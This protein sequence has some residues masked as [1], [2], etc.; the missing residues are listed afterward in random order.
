MLQLNTHDSYYGTIT[1]L[2]V[3]PS[4][5]LISAE[6]VE[7]SIEALNAIPNYDNLECRIGVY[8]AAAKSYS[9][10]SSTGK[11]TI[12]CVVPSYAS[13]VTDWD[14]SSDITVTVDVSNNG[15]EF[16]S[17]SVTFV[18]INQLTLVTNIS[19]SRGPITAGS[20][21]SVYLRKTIV[22]SDYNPVCKFGDVSVA[23]TL[24]SA[25]VLACSTK[26]VFAK[27]SPAYVRCFKDYYC[28]VNGSF[29]LQS[30]SYPFSYVF[31]PDP[32][33]TSL[34]P[35]TSGGAQT[36]SVLVRGTGMFSYFQSPAAKFLLWGG[37]S[38]Q[39]DCQSTDYNTSIVCTP[40]YGTLFAT[41]PTLPQ[42]AEV[43]MSV[44]SGLD[45]SADLKNFTFSA[46][47]VPSSLSTPSGPNTGNTNLTIKYT[48]IFKYTDPANYDGYR[49]N[50]TTSANQA[51]FVVPATLNSTVEEL[52]CVTPA[53]DKID[54]T[55]SGL[56]YIA[57]SS[58]GITYSS[59]KLT[60][61]Y[62]A[63]AS[64]TTIDSPYLM[65]D[66]QATRKITGTFPAADSAITPKIRLI[67]AGTTKSQVL[68][69]LSYSTTEVT[70]QTVAGIFAFGD[71][72]QLAISLNGGANFQTSPYVLKAIG[73]AALSSVL[74]TIIHLGT[75]ASVINLLGA[76]FYNLPLYCVQG[77]ASPVLASRL[78]SRLI[79]CSFPG[80]ASETTATI[81]VNIE[82]YPYSANT[83]S[84]QYKAV[85]TVTGISQSAVSAGKPYN[86]TFTLGA[87]GFSPLYVKIS[88]LVFLCVAASSTT[89]TAA[90]PGLS[91]P[92]TASI[93]FS[94]N[95]NYFQQSSLQ[96][97]LQSCVAGQVCPSSF[98]S[99]Q[100]PTTCTAGTICPD[101]GYQRPCPPGYYQS[102]TG[103]S[104]C[105]VCPSGSYCPTQGTVAPLTCPDGYLCSSLGT[106]FKDEM[107]T[108]PE[109]F[110]CPAGT[111]SFDRSKA[112]AGTGYMYYC[113]EGFWCGY[114]VTTG[115]N[116]YGRFSTAQKCND[117][118]VCTAG[119]IDQTGTKAC[120][121][122]YYCNDGIQSV[123]DIGS[124][125]PNAN[126]TAPMKCPPGLFSNTTGQTYCGPCPLGTVC[127]VQGDTYPYKCPPG[128]VC[129]LSG[130]VLFTLLCP[131]GS[132]CVG[133]IVTNKTT[134]TVL[135]AYRPHLCSAGTYCLP[136]TRTNEVIAG[137]AGAAQA[138]MEG[139]YCKEGSD[140]QDYCPEGYYCPLGS[141]PI[142]ADPGYFASGKGNVNEEACAPGTY[143]SGYASASCTVCPAGY[144]C[145]SEATVTPI[146]CAEGTYK[147]KDANIIQCELCP[148][149][150]WSNQTGLTSVSDCITCDAGIVCDQEGTTNVTS[151]ARSCPE[152]YICGA[153]TTSTTENSNP[154]PE[155]YWC[156][157]GTGLRRQIHV[158]DKG[159][160]CTNTTTE[161]GRYYNKCP[162]GYYCPRGTAANI[163]EESD[164]INILTV[165]ST[166]YYKAVIA[167]KKAYVEYVY[168]TTGK[169]VTD[170][171]LATAT[172]CDEDASLPTDL[173]TSY[174]SLQCPNGTTSA[175]SSWCLGQCNI[176]VTLTTKQSV[177][178]PVLNTTGSDVAKAAD[179]WSWDIVNDALVDYTLSPLSYAKIT[180]D[181]TGL[182]SILTYND[183][184]QIVL[185][186]EN[187][188][189][190]TLPNYFDSSNDAVANK[191]AKLQIRVVNVYS[192][193]KIMRVGIKILNGLYLPY[194]SYFSDTVNV[195][196]ASPSRAE[197]GTNRLFGIFLYYQSLSSITLPYNMRNTSVN[198][199]TDMT[200]TGKN[201]SL[202]RKTFDQDPFDITLW[203]SDSITT[204]A[205]PWLP[206]FSSCDGQ[207]RHIYLYDLLED[208]SKCTLV[209]SQDTVVVTE[210]PTSGI[211]TNADHCNTEFT[212]RYEENL[213][214]SVS[215]STR[216]YQIT[217]ATTLFYITRNPI[218]PDELLGLQSGSDLESTF[219]DSFKGTISDDMIPVVFSPTQGSSDGVPTLVEINI[220]YMQKTKTKK[221]IVKAQGYFRDYTKSILQ[222]TEPKYRVVIN[223]SPMDYFDLIENFQFDPSVYVVLLCMFG[224]VLLIFVA[225]FWAINVCIRR[226][227]A[228][229]VMLK[230]QHIFEVT[231]LPPIIVIPFLVTH[232]REARWPRSPCS[233]P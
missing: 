42:K 60:F 195:T 187:N 22:V 49:C 79:A 109:G 185:Y 194:A 228:S 95:A 86:L 69:A 46:E 99:Y 63:E 14:Y 233:A 138:C 92:L 205:L 11:S 57:I 52:Y 50:F 175:K 196:V 115:T 111:T 44:N 32:H 188:A 157:K 7:I 55:T 192:Q 71:T 209:S 97:T 229:V 219:A 217:S 70:F 118:V 163:T 37:S 96:L 62:Y 191:T 184:Y 214:V 151:Q 73:S 106:A 110:Y 2:K 38:V 132:Y 197:Y 150:T 80:S 128:Y 74:P 139:F 81:S 130:Q 137:D 5:S 1:V 64:F 123:C 159:Y 61:E 231:F 213:T 145:P 77:S 155:G 93:S 17:S 232:R 65:T 84:L 220:K 131:G 183:V 87:A 129:S 125:C 162:K 201:I 27:I 21:V 178:D 176:D 168:N 227:T 116:T 88:D 135:S 170:D 24:A 113:P 6:N 156:A 45:W 100:D 230:L 66:Q 85:P 75:A 161:T 31:Y 34:L 134:S 143:S 222:D 174:T 136:G 154:C 67:T 8:I 122:G 76:T 10:D 225:V 165:T 167:E 15:I 98:N 51:G 152:G 91:Y 35:Q 105:I 117:G 223:F 166:D 164:I 181:F 186:D 90:F 48:N 140:G 30:N 4:F 104:T 204:I 82:S 68:S 169:T 102:G 144:Y 180:F 215:S 20:T 36:A 72:V 119:S 221:A 190:Q 182:P 112:G 83:V 101:D 29:E 202:V 226:A 133:G 16:S 211:H 58:N 142:A 127:S 147:E 200:A 149:G 148:E 193:S 19:P 18:F 41:T 146:I 78:T 107:Q 206:F 212:C 94:Q 3:T 172:T 13:T 126:M 26:G 33:V 160:F 23:A 39:V 120:S 56:A 199:T 103:T 208:A 189:T 177:V 141:D 158:C 216:W 12:V 173:K 210:F 43:E 121:A 108:C 25:L 9:Y 59:T 53:K 203:A 40:P 179:K 89:C 124:Y 114:A 153:G 224:I 218:T 28:A 171:D 198:M 47:D 54:G 207:D